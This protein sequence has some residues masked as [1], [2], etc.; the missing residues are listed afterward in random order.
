MLLINGLRSTHVANLEP[1]RR[2]LAIQLE[3]ELN[4]RYGVMVGQA[5][6]Q[7]REA[8]LRGN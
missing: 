5:G 2:R 3:T 1:L 8:E 6:D 4:T 7:E